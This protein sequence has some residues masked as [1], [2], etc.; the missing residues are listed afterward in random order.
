MHRPSRILPLLVLALLPE[1]R[2]CDLDRPIPPPASRARLLDVATAIADGSDCRVSLAPGL[3]DRA[4]RLEV[5]SDTPAAD[6][7]DALSAALDLDWRAEADGTIVLLA[8]QDTAA[9]D[10]RA[11]ELDIEADARRREQAPRMRDALEPDL[12][13]ERSPIVPRTDIGD[14]RVE[15]EALR[16]FSTAVLRAPGVYSMAATDAIRGISAPRLPV[17]YRASLVSIDGIPLPAEANYFGQFDLNLVASMSVVRTGTGL[18]LAF[19]AGAGHIAVRTA[20]PGDEPGGVLRALASSD[21]APRASGSLQWDFGVPGLA[22]SLGASGQLEDEA[23]DTDRDPDVYQDQQVS[24]RWRYDSPEG[25]HGLTGSLLKL[26]NAQVGGVRTP[27]G[28]CGGGADFCP[29]GSDVAAAGAA[30]NYAWQWSDAL[31]LSAHGAASDSDAAVIRLVQGALVRAPEV[32]LRLRYADLRLDW[33]GMGPMS[34]SVGAAYSSRRRQ[35][36]QDNAYFLGDVADESGLVAASAGAEAA[37]RWQRVNARV[38]QLPQWFAEWRYDDGE[39]WDAALGVRQ[40]A[41]RSYTAT[42]FRDIAAVNCRVEPAAGGGDCAARF[43][44]LVLGPDVRHEADRSLPLGQASLR[45]R[46]DSGHWVSAAVRQSFGI[47]DYFPA[48]SPRGAVER[49]DTLE[50]AWFAPLGPDQHLETRLYHHQWDDRTGT[51]DGTTPL[52]FDSEVT[53]LEA[54]YLWRI[55]ENGELWANGS[56]IVTG[57]SLARDELVGAPAWTAGFGGRWRFDSGW[58]VGAHFSRVAEARAAA[59]DGT[60]TPLPAR[61]LL[62]ARVGWRHGAFDVSLFGTNL[63]DDEYVLDQQG[64]DFLPEIYEAPDRMVGLDVAWRF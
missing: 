41:T 49:I 18:G 8:Y 35:T 5:A 25:R 2:A 13:A 51:R 29:A 21:F 59:F 52:L 62:D 11:D 47:S 1:A 32:D 53:G 46:F 9:A 30:L 58:Y 7:L 56:R 43:R 16:D 3:A 39:R 12:P 61:D 38:Y 45:R 14:E 40:F 34:A 4:A 10:Y 24:L 22:T 60:L 37:I 6:V 54:E 19:G 57:T 36:A 55:D 42:E 50:L 15:D 48:T 17:G 28:T 31:V 63:L 64:R 20:T 27:P 23:L 44:D 26:D 33:F